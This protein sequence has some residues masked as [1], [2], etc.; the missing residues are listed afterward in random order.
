M[1]LPSLYQNGQQPLYNLGMN[2]AK[3][4]KNF[5]AFMKQQEKEIAKELSCPPQTVDDV[6]EEG[7]GY[8]VS[9]ETSEAALQKSEKVCWIS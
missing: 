4:S 9:L 6:K 8:L 5:V 7:K 2:G 1:A 3:V